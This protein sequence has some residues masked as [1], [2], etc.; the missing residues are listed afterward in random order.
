MH[1]QFYQFTSLVRLVCQD[2]RVPYSKVV[3]S[4]RLS[5]SVLG[6]WSLF[7]NVRSVCWGAPIIPCG[8][9]GWPNSIICLNLIYLSL[10]YCLYQNVAH[11]IP[12]CPRSYRLHPTCCVTTHDFIRERS[13][14]LVCLYIASLKWN[15]LFIDVSSILSFHFFF[16]LVIVKVNFFLS[17]LPA[18]SKGFA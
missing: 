6:L 17:Y 3:C 14:G 4:P 11:D 13:V 15:V 8:D 2:P 18:L 16:F 9:R 7:K 12:S 5:S 1:L 10:K